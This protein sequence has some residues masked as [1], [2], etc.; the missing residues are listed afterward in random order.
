[1]DMFLDLTDRFPMRF[2]VDRMRQEVRDV[3]SDSL[4][5]EHY[6]KALS[7]GWKAI[8]L[9][10][11][12][13]RMDGPESQRWGDIRECRRTPVVEKMPYFREILD[14]FRCPHGRIRVLK[15]MPGAVIGMHRD[16]ADEAAGFAYRKVRLHVPIETNDGVVFHLGGGRIKM[17]PGRLYYCDFTQPHF[18]RN[19]GPT[20]R[21]H[22]VMDLIV[23]DFL[24]GVF[25]KETLREKAV[26]WLKR[27]AMPTVWACQSARVEA[28][29]RFWRAYNGSA[30]QGWAQ[31][32]RGKK[33]ALAASAAE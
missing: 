17:A 28:S 32:V 21:V 19:D 13:G 6:D 30:V 31:A 26:H 1:M 22:L 4:W 7:T 23:N 9:V 18:V 5:L 12:H 33:P 25:P 14:A 24:M 20:P 29:R 2:D 10:S 3:Q 11:R 8:P 15:L 16:I 27:N